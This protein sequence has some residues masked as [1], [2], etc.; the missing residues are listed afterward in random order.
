[1]VGTRGV[2]R[3]ICLQD[4][5][6]R[7]WRASIIDAKAHNDSAQQVGAPTSAHGQSIAI[8]NRINIG[9]IAIASWQPLHRERPRHLLP[10]MLYWNQEGMEC[11]S[12]APGCQQAKIGSLAG[13][14]RLP[15]YRLQD[16]FHARGQLVEH[17]R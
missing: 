17:L 13:G 10:V 1:M 3:A 11:G 6:D 12:I 2:D 14:L 9:A 7:R 15:S 8:G 4:G 5:C 16:C